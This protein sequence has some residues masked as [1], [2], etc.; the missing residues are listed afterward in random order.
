MLRHLKR[1][2]ALW[3][4]SWW[5][6][7]SV[8]ADVKKQRIDH[9]STTVHVITA[10]APEEIDYTSYG[11]DHALIIDNTGAFLTKEALSRH[12]TKGAHKV[13]LTAPGKEYQILFMV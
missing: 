8:T 13:L 4:N 12:L 1:G 7:G 9:K 10:N 11:I 5:F 2:F 6:Q 3:L